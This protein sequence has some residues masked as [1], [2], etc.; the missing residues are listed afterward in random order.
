MTDR[1]SPRPLEGL[2]AALLMSFAFLGVASLQ[3]FSDMNSLL[4]RTPI[5]DTVVAGSIWGT[6]LGRNLVLFA[7][8]LLLLHFLPHALNA[9]FG[10]LRAFSCHQQLRFH[11]LYF[12]GELIG[13]AV[14]FGPHR[15]RLELRGK[16]SDGVLTA[17]Q[18]L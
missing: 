1:S 17:R 14:F 9:I 6:T 15:Q 11:P 8:A 12:R 7:L 16:T 3:K 18:S 10:I 5:I 2:F 4:F 13:Q